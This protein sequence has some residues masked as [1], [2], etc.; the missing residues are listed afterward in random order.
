MFV[1]SGINEEF[2]PITNEK[3]F[4]G[5]TRNIIFNEKIIAFDEVNGQMYITTANK[6][7]RLEDD[8]LNFTPVRIW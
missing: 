4:K 1:F 5:L 8:G 2:S 3:M 6:I 7:Y